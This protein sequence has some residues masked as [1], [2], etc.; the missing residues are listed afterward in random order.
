LGQ[1]IKLILELITSGNTVL[2]TKSTKGP[3]LKE[4]GRKWEKELSL[5]NLK[6][7]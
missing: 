3:P 6:Y 4:R 1:E 5:E 7:S 2:N